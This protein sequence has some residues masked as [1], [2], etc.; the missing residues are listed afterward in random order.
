MPIEVIDMVKMAHEEGKRK[1]IF[2]TKKL[3]Y[4]LHVYPAPGDKDD[5]H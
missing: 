3:H 1:V 4:W 5:M 2:N